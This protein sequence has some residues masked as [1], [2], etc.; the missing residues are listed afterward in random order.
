MSKEWSS[1][2]EDRR[3]MESW[4]KHINEEDE[5]AH[6]AEQVENFVNDE[7]E[8]DDL[9]L[10]REFQVPG[11]SW[12]V[13]FY[14]VSNEALA[15]ASRAKFIPEDARTMIAKMAEANQVLVDTMDEFQEKNPKLYNSVMGAVMVTDVG[16]TVISKGKE[17][18]LKAM[19]TV[20]S[21][22][23]HLEPPATAA[24]P[25]PQVS[26]PP[27]FPSTDRAK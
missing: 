6:L 25:A 1:F 16:G 4:R 19:R 3:I 18:F 21:K 20:L 17:Y 2:E 26:P 11:L 15:I 7:K 27:G 8:D 10:L 14:R 22:R 13:N 9:Q 24:P 23:G 12:V 5:F